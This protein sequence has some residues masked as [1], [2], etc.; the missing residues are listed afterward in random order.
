[1]TQDP[2]YMKEILINIQV[3]CANRKDKLRGYK[4]KMEYAK[5]E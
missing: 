4:I 1:M 2:P 5:N 3:N